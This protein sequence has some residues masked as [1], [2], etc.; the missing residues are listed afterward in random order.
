MYTCDDDCEMTTYNMN[1]II[2][3]RLCVPTDR[4]FARCLHTCDPI[5]KGLHFN[6]HTCLCFLWIHT[7]HVHRK[8]V[9]FCLHLSFQYVRFS[10]SSLSGFIPSVSI[11]S[12]RIRAHVYMF[13]TR[14]W[15]PHKQNTCKQ[16]N[17]KQNTYLCL[18]IYS[19]K[20]Y[21]KQFKW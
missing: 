3:I 19:Y 1:I 20:M 6:I 18:H 4:G 5:F 17:A 9:H 7:Y 10:T 11:S 12:T 13:A 21:I 2:I 14:L 16:V 8:K 15:N